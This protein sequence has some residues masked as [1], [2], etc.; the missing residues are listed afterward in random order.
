MPSIS[1]AVGNPYYE[2]YG[3]MS[4]LQ[5]V[6]KSIEIQLRLQSIFRKEKITMGVLKL[7]PKVF[8]SSENPSWLKVRT[9]LESP[10]DVVCRCDALYFWNAD[11][12]LNAIHA[13][14]YN[15]DIRTVGGL[16]SVQALKREGKPGGAGAEGRSLAEA[17]V[18]V[19]CEILDISLEDEGGKE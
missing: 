17:A 3:D 12:S 11:N 16:I 14:G 7:T 19:L 4:R 15:V 9:C 5:G 1:F 6:K 18:K 13:L 8:S 2:I 10:G